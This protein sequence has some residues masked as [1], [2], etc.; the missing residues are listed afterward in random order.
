MSSDIYR[1][2]WVVVILAFVLIGFDIGPALACPPVPP[3]DQVANLIRVPLVRQGKDYTCGVAA[4]HSVIA[5]Y[6]EKELDD[7]KPIR[8]DNLIRKLRTNPHHGTNYRNI[9][10]YAEDLDYDA[11]MYTGE[12]F[13]WED[14]Q[15][16]IDQGKP[17]IVIIQAWAQKPVDWPNDWEDGHYVVAVGYDDCYVYFINPSTLGNYTY[18]PR[19]EFLERWHDRD[20][21]KVFNHAAIVIDG[22][23]PAYDPNKIKRL[24]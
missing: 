14:L 23:P 1:K 18:I 15:A 2:F 19:E 12:S 6:G 16:F 4:F 22:K 10:A 24:E 3:L 7:G 5:Y 17:T 13:G 8:E 9:L 11:V 21:R 20:R